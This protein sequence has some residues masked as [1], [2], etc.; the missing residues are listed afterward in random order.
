M[1]TQ[2]KELPN[3]ELKDIVGYEGM[4][5]VSNLGRVKSL[6]FGKNLILKSGFS[7]KGYLLLKLSKNNTSKTFRVHRLVAAAFIKNPH[8]K[9]DINHINGIKDDN[10]VENLE[11]NTRSENIQHAFSIGLSKAKKGEKHNMSKLTTQQ[12]LAIRKDN[13]IQR[14]IAKDY[15]VSRVQ[16]SHIKRKKIWNHL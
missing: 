12:V 13:R 16:I 10:R 11:W 6:K 5:Q 8:K 2:K 1:K 9:S 4:Y 15:N 14:E 7:A 3:E